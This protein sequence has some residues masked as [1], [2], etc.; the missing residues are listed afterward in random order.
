[1]RAKFLGDEATHGYLFCD[2]LFKYHPKSGLITPLLNSAGKKGDNW[3]IGD[4]QYD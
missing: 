3:F 1:L 2:K 4:K